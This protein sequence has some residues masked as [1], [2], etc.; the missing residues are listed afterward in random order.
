MKKIYFVHVPKTAGTFIKHCYGDYKGF[1][2]NVRSDKQHKF[3]GK[4]KRLGNTCE[5]W[6]R[7]KD[8]NY[9]PSYLDDENYHQ[10]DFRFSI[11]RSP[12]DWL[13]SYYHHSS[14]FDDGWANV[15]DTSGFKTFKDFVIGF[16]GMRDEDWHVPILSTTPYGQIIND[17]NLMVDRWFKQES[18]EQLHKYFSDNFHM[19]PRSSRG[20]IRK[21]SRRKNDDYRMYYDTDM[22]KA[23]TNKMSFELKYFDYRF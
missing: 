4:A 17:G 7:E 21:S 3:P 22:I 5:A 18:L 20:R 12:F 16:C 6:R 1:Y 8:T 23:V 14:R 15:N 2:P 11:V 19:T 10:A 9:F 13:V